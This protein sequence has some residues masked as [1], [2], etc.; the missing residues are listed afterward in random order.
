MNV[1]NIH[2]EK[3]KHLKNK[4]AKML[5]FLQR[6]L[7]VSLAKYFNSLYNYVI[8]ESITKFWPGSLNWNTPLNYFYLS[9]MFVII[10][11]V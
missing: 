10:I 3:I 6:N 2:L 1:R 7:D 5:D 9:S 11:V 8:M 4:L